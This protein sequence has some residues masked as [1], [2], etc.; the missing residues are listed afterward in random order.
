MDTANT[1]Y[2]GKK[3]PATNYREY[4]RLRTI[5]DSLELGAIRYF[6][7]GPNKGERLAKV[8][9]LLHEALDFFW[10]DGEGE[11]APIDCPEGYTNCHG[12]C[13]PYQCPG[14]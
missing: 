11:S 6:M 14:A 8:E 10:R 4:A 12:A 7:S 9:S 1:S 2:S 5:T 13:V 3:S